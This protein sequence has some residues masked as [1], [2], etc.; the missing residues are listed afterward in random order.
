M[1]LR[2][3]RKATKG[4]CQL[5]AALDRAGQQVPSVSPLVQIPD[6]IFQR[7]FFFQKGGW[8]FDRTT[9]KKGGLSLLLLFFFQQLL[10]PQ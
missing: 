7:E 3:H 9:S 4:L 8:G 6:E 2:A 1:P 10:L 5:A